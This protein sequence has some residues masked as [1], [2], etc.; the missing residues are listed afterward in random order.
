LRRAID[1]IINQ[2]DRNFELLIVDDNNGGRKLL[3]VL[4]EYAR[5]QNIAPQHVPIRIVRTTSNEG[6]AKTLDF[7]ISEAKGELIVR[8][9]SDDLA[10]PELLARHRAFFESNPEAAICGVQLRL[11]YKD[12]RMKG[13]TRHPAEV[14]REY[15]IN[16]N[17]F[18]I[19]NH[20]GIC[21]RKSVVTALG[22][23]GDTPKHLAEDYKLWCKFL[24]ANY[25]IHNLPDVMLDYTLG[26]GSQIGQSRE[27][28][29][30]KE[31]LQETRKEL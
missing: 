29:E 25:V 5:V 17:G 10:Y 22:G 12:G 2:T 13:F 28:A 24:K 1:S 23:Y 4:N 27:G 26:D 18:W 31:F 30:W 3:D 9:D 6:L 15:A 21:Y 7:G 16:M 20:P 11:M 19:T 8:M 14:N